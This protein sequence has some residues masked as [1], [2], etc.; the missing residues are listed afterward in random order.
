MT[1]MAEDDMD[2]A[3]VDTGYDRGAPEEA[4]ETA[5]SKPGSRLVDYGS[6]SE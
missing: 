1:N 6:D 5:Q 3:G 2:D 4:Y